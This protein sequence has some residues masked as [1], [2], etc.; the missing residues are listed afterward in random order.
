MKYMGDGFMA[1]FP[2]SADDAAATALAIPGL[3]S[4]LPLLRVG[5][6]LHSGAVAIGAVGERSRL[7]GDVMSDVANVAC[8]LESLTRDHAATTLLSARTH[9]LLSKPYQERSTPL[10][11]MPVKGR[12]GSVEVFLLA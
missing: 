8:R 1:V 10:G 11:K 5:I 4:S 9:E 2:R 3:V 6:G 12:S 7:Q